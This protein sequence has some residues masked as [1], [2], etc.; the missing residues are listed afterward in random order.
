MNRHE[1]AAEQLAKKLKYEAR[2]EDDVR[3]VF[4]RMAKE[5]GALYAASGALLD[6]E[7]YRDDF[8][9]IL[10]N[11]YRR[12][13]DDFGKTLRRQIKTAG[14]TLDQKTANVEAALA[15]FTHTATAASADYITKT[16]EAY[17]AQ[18]LTTAIAF[19]MQNGEEPTKDKVGKELEASIR[20][21]GYGRGGTIATTETQNAA[22]G[23]KFI[24][25]TELAKNA[26][27][28][29]GKPITATTVRVWTAILDQKT[30]LWHAVADGQRREMQTPF[31]VHG[32]RMAYPGD[33]SHGATTENIVNCRCMSNISLVESETR[34]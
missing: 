27:E 7:T 4:R 3:R 12:V 21:N 28:V 23:A 2:L 17:L 9:A 29:D 11:G 10:K 13:T 25:A 32:E 14:L 15:A 18:A 33:R 1:M 24:E 8:T 30:R 16:N 31:D 6:A 22:E 34:L 5:A 26:A 19:V 20:R